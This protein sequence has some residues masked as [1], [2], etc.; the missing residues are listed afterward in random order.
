MILNIEKNIYFKDKKLNIISYTN[1]NQKLKIILEKETNINLLINEVLLE[2][3]DKK[4]ICLD[5]F[6]KCK[7]LHL[8]RMQIEDHPFDLYFLSDDLKL[9]IFDKDY[10]KKYFIF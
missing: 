7:I 4:Y 8:K 5:C 6:P 3:K 9:V 10:E 2:K 1:N